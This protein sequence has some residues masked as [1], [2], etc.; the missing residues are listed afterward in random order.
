MKP[1]VIHSI[2]A[3]NFVRVAVVSPE[4]RVA[5]VAFN[6]DHMVRA[7]HALGKSGVR[8]AVF[9]ELGITGYTC[10]DL[11]Y[12][13]ALRDAAEA[14]VT[15]LSEAVRESGVT[16]VV[17][18]PMEIHNR[19][20]NVAMLI[21]EH[22]PAGIVTK[23]FLP[24]SNE[25]Y[26]ERW[27]SRAGVLDTDAVE[28]FG[29]IVPIGTD[30]IF[31][32][33]NHR[34]FCLGL[35][36]CEDLWAVQP[37]SG[38]LAL[39]GAT[40]I[41]NPS[42]SD[43]LLG[44]ANYR[45]TLVAQ[46]SARCLAAYLYA[47]AGPGESSTDLVYSG[48]SMITENGA[49]LAET[50]RFQPDTTWAIADIDLDFLVSERL[51]N[52]SFSATP[53]SADVRV[54][55]FSL[56]CAKAEA[57]ADKLHRTLSA[58]PFVP[59]LEADRG[60]HCSEVFAIQSAGLGTRLRH[61]PGARP[62][63]GISGGLDSTLA[64]LV[65]IEAMKQANR[66]A[67][68][69]LAV[70][71]PGPGST[72]L[73]QTNA[74]SLADMLGVEVREI[75]I[76]AAVQSHLRDISHPDHQFDITF[77]NAQARERTQILMDL[78]NQ[79]GGLVIG[80]GDLSE[81]ALGWCTFNGD[82]LSMYHVNIGV[83]KTLVRYVIEWVAT[84]T[85]DAGLAATLRSIGNTPITPE[86]LP[87]DA[88]GALVQRTEETLGSYDLHDFFLFH[89]VRRHARPRKVFA[90]ACIAFA[91]TCEPAEILKTLKTF[92]RRFFASQFKRSAMPDGPKVGTV[93]LSPRGDWRMP[94]DARPDLWLAECDAIAKQINQPAA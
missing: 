7:L 83:P 82:H 61:V 4:L 24:S 70:S 2:V 90:L 92:Y 13:P 23:S 14:A 19:L 35:E 68:D 67:R 75:P 63:I 34:E 66:P 49:P 5:D 38:A 29:K 59:E 28:L 45:R 43:E 86:L 64:L 36:I 16:A 54:V 22:G 79:V 27:F 46:Q 50:T 53:S 33:E 30:L 55:S 65:C 39:A 48:H 21:D 20:Y 52:S 80:T 74:R 40:V 73:T 31:Q 18:L 78:A 71:M 62:V 10:A 93:A 25:F 84:Q 8:L 51:K 12:Q 69:I 9:P 47:S 44:K 77:E 89:A 11:F 87:L 37:P 72:A 3:E 42:A 76:H 94:S 57:D 1:S 85:P 58:R 6:T 17:G 91:D 56:G 26:E 60:A 41:A 32:A 88:D 15:A 81:A